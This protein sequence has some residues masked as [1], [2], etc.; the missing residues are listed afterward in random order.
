MT[1]ATAVLAALPW[2]LAPVIA[3]VRMR[4]S[5]SLDSISDAVPDRPPFVSVVIPARN[6][7]RNIER[8]LSSVIATTYPHAEF[9]VVDDHSND[10]TREL[11]LRVAADDPRVRVLAS[12]DLPPGWFG[13]QWACWTGVREARGD[14][15]VFI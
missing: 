6:E 3:V 12:P 1:P 14:V 9:I 5:R 2:A 7:A 10:G 8:C 4:R 13:K 15:L 11:A